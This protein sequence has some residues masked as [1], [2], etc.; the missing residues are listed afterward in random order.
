V[1]AGSGEAYV[2]TAWKN[3]VYA[4]AG[5]HLDARRTEAMIMETMG[6]WARTSA[7]WA[8]EIGW[9]KVGFHTEFIIVQSGAWG[10]ARRAAST[11]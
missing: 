6:Q 10:H 1:I 11:A 5:T 3:E 8:Y 2:D 4:I 7:L 9:C